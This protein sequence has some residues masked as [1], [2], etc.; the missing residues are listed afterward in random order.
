MR[1]GIIAGEFYALWH[2]P[3]TISP[4]KLWIK[5]VIGPA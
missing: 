4:G 1:L 5:R 2:N 3:E